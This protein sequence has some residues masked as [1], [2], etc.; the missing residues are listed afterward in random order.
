MPSPPLPT[1]AGTAVAVVAVAVLALAGCGQDVDDSAEP[2]PDPTVQPA[3]PTA[4]PSDP[5]PDQSDP[6]P[7]PSD[8]YSEPPDSDPDQDGTV[9]PLTD[10]RSLESR[11]DEGGGSLLTVTDVRVGS[12]EDFDRV[13]FELAGDG[14]AG[15]HIAYEDTPTTPGQG[16]PIAIDG[17]AFLAVFIRGVAIPPDAPAHD[18][19]DG[20]RLDGPAGATVAEIVHAGIY[21][22]QHDFFIGV[23]EKAPFGV[24]RLDDPQRIVVEFDRR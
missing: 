13:V 2:T 7:D 17:E 5:D 9:E 15:W 6:D 23:R 18:P 24:V 22:G 11:T 3:D 1:R 8:P 21:E 20:E 4:D 14:P 19:W 12:Y 16:A 10:Q